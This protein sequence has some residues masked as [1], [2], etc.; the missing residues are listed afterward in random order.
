MNKNINFNNGSIVWCKECTFYDVYNVDIDDDRIEL[1]DE[2]GFIIGTIDTSML[3]KC[4]YL[5]YDN[6]GRFSESNRL[7]KLATAGGD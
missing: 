1:N 7:A 3:D 5:S 2:S 6:D 4:Y